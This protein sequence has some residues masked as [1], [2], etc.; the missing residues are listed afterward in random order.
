MDYVEV[1]IQYMIEYCFGLV[2]ICM[3]KLQGKKIE[4]Q[5]VVE[6]L[7][8][9][10]TLMEKLQS[11]DDKLKYKI[12]KLLAIASAGDESAID[13]RLSYRAN[14]DNF[15]VID[16]KNEK[17]TQFISYSHQTKQQ[18]DMSLK[19]LIQSYLMLKKIKSIVLSKNKES[20]ITLHIN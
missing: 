5:S 14:L 7:V 11:L 4:G 13:A 18:K 15:T 17:S 3:M 19:R 10:K 6:R 16:K 9:I 2:Y 8:K 20:I 1:K 12:E